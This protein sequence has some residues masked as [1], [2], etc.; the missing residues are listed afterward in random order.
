MEDRLRG[1]LLSHMEVSSTFRA[2]VE[3]FAGGALFN[4]LAMDDETAAEA[5]KYVRSG[6]TSLEEVHIEYFYLI[7]V[8][9]HIYNLM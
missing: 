2:A 9:L 5:V 3:S 1:T 4:I 6:E 7:Y 8:Y